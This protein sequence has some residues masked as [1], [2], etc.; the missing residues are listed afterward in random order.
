MEAAS[1]GRWAEAATALNYCPWRCGAER[2][3]EEVDHGP[4]LRRWRSIARIDEVYS[5]EIGT[6]Y[7]Q[8]DGFK[9]TATNR[10]SDD[11]FGLVEDPEARNGSCHQ[12]VAIVGPQT[13]RHRHPLVCVGS[14]RPKA[15]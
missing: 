6:R 9:L 7:I 2:G 3:D 11:E 8:R 14:E 1:A 10:I 15:G 4:D 12:R 13:S 5:A